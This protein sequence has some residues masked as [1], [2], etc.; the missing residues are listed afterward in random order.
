MKN[1]T[2]F[3]RFGLSLVAGQ[4]GK[5]RI[6]VSSAEVRSARVRDLHIVVLRISQGNAFSGSS[7]L[8]HG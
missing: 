8:S 5:K 2:K 1:S 3:L 6:A 4:K 7:A